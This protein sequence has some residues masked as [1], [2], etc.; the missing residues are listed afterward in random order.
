M[1]SVLLTKGQKRLVPTGRNAAAGA[2]ANLCQQPKANDTIDSRW[3]VTPGRPPR[4]NATPLA[5]F[6]Q[7]DG[8]NHRRG[9][10]VK[11]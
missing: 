11:R 2:A 6:H 9:R 5:Q 10:H 3:R 4:Y 1:L 8:A 7:A